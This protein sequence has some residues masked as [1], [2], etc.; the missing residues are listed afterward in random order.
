MTQRNEITRLGLRI[1]DEQLVDC[2]GR[3]CGR[4]EDLEFDGGPGEVVHAVGILC[5]ATAWKRRL[6]PR[7]AELIPG[8]PRALHR[9][10]WECVAKIANEIE[11]RLREDELEPASAG[12]PAPMALSDLLAATVTD[13][14]GEPL[15]RVREVVAERPCDADEGTPWRLHSLL[16]GHSALLQRAGF[17]PDLTDDIGQERMPGNLVRWEWV[18]G[19]DGP[20][21]I[22][23]TDRP[24]R[25]T[26]PSSRRGARRR[27]RG[28]RD[29]D[30]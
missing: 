26:L 21:R 30:E 13:P 3:R 25:P 15:G 18:A 6:P 28:R 19:F 7:L 2:E 14:N 9:V 5:G 16:V 12:G 11:L 1:L 8:D 23:L 4:V 29:G 22:A 27:G 20:R 17:A 10:P 24:P